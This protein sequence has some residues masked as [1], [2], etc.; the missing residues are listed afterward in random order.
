MA[1]L[2]AGNENRQLE[3]LPRADFGRLPELFLLSVKTKSITE[4]FVNWKLR[5]LFIFEVFQRI[6]RLE[7]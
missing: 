4:N 6:F 2:A 7:P 1:F 5:P 3:G